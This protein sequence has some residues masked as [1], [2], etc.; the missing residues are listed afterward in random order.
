[1]KIRFLTIIVAILCS[2]VSWAQVPTTMS[3]Q[4]M[5]VNPKTNILI[6]SKEV[7][8]R[9][10]LRK[11]W[12]GGDVVWAKDYT[13]TTS[14]SGICTLSL[15]F[16]SVNWNSGSFYLATIIDGEEAGTSQIQSVPYAMQAQSLSCAVSKDFLVGTWKRAIGGGY[17]DILFIFNE[18]NTASRITGFEA[19]HN[20]VE[21]VDYYTY[22]ID[23]AGN[24]FLKP[25]STTSGDGIDAVEHMEK[26]SVVMSGERIFI[27]YDERLYP[28]VRQK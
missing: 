20:Y 3:Y 16:S 8:I 23:G 2:M 9:I 28:Y 11:G 14:A 12:R 21:Y 10:E 1:M 19:D 5:V 6:A 4:I 26:Y 18:D 7:S 17:D 13:A 24:L 25:T 15:D 22:E 27:G